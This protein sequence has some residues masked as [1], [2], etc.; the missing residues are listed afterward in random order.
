MRALLCN[1]V[2][3]WLGTS[4][5]SAL[6]SCWSDVWPILGPSYGPIFHKFSTSHILQIHLVAMLVLL[7][8]HPIILSMSLNCMWSSA[9]STFYWLAFKLIKAW[10]KWASFCRWHLHFGITVPFWFN[11]TEMKSLLVLIMAWTQTGDKPLPE[12]MMTQSPGS[13]YEVTLNLLC[14]KIFGGNINMFTFFV[15]EPRHQ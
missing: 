5:E 8:W 1:D 6:D 7:D 15:K 9:A 12:R 10:M 13:N 2:S 11:F 4:L 14:A 3:H